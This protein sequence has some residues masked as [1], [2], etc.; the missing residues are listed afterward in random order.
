M[1]STIDVCMQFILLEYTHHPSL[2]IGLFLGT[3][4]VEMLIMRSA[5]KKCV[6]VSTL[7]NGRFARLCAGSSALFTNSSSCN[8]SSASSPPPLMIELY[9]N[10]SYL[11]A[12]SAQIAIVR[13]YDRL[14]KLLP[15]YYRQRRLK[16]L[17]DL[18]M[19][20]TF[21]LKIPKG[22]YVYGSIGTGK[23]MLMDMF[24]ENCLL[25]P[26]KKKRVHFHKFCLDMH[27]RI[28]EI[29]KYTREVENVI[30]S[31]SDA[32][33]IIGE[34]LSTET[35]LLCFDEFQVTDIADALMLSKLFN[36]L[37]SN[38]T[39]L[40]ATSNRPPI[41]L[42]KDGLNRQYFLPFIDTLQNRCLV[43]HIDTDVDH[44]L[45]FDETHEGD[46]HN[47][48]TSSSSLQ[49]SSFYTP[50]NEQTK[51]Q[52]WNQFISTSRENS[53][54]AELRENMSIA[55]MMNRHLKIPFSRGRACFMS[56]HDLCEK[57]CSAADFKALCEVFA[58]VYLHGIPA[59]SVIKHDEARRFITLIDEL[60][61]ARIR[62]T[63]T[64][65]HHPKD[66]FN[67]NVHM[68]GDDK[69]NLI[70]GTDHRW[71]ITDSCVLPKRVIDLE[72]ENSVNYDPSI[73]P[74]KSSTD[75]NKATAEVKFEGRV[76]EL[77]ILEGEL[78]SV[79]ELG[80]AFKRA[81]SRMVE[82]GSAGYR[83]SIDISFK[84]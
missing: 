7:R 42:Y 26:E 11:K 79:Q 73:P 51:L 68:K 2:E 9:Q 14:N 66:L 70:L 34:Q 47:S 56:F 25:P 18:R 48:M 82:M 35:F 16:P 81:A 6:S 60:Y 23:T 22:L 21:T 37:W 71:G 58:D 27:R 67:T 30:T 15:T 8:S 46:D 74:P 52:L 31:E 80:F 63:W 12:N 77:D 33:A 69:S 43:R 19:D 84:V 17:Y 76:E 38:G 32:I 13:V 54:G 24:Y 39:I 28:H 4:I 83:D 5:L 36:I 45:L 3:L 40:I 65:E 20:D 59:M 75:I 50:V 57:E 53:G 1:R 62:L 10:N 49:S 61:D 72:S 55:V 29:K 44:R 64:S 41:D 78:A